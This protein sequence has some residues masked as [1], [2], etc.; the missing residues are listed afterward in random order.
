MVKNLRD[1]IDILIYNLFLTQLTTLA[2]L[3]M[4]TC[5]DSFSSMSLISKA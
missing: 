4:V 1:K 5:F 3:W 2:K